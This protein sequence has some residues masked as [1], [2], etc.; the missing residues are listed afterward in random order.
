MT[1]PLGLLPG[2]VRGRDALLAELRRRLTKRS[3]VGCGTWVLAGMGGLGKSTVALAV[4]ATAREAGWR[5]WWVTA[6]DAPSLTGGMLEVLQQLG[7]PEAVTRPVREGAR[8]AAERAWE[9][10]NSAHEVGRRW[11]LIFDNADT[12]AVLAAHGS[13]CP[14]DHAGWLRPD[15]AGMILVTSRVKDPHAWGPGVALRELQPL[16]DAAAARVL[17]DL[18]PGIADPGSEQARELGRRLGGLPLAL[19]LAGSHLA[20]PF[21][22]WDTFAAYRDALD[23]TALPA[24]LAE[25]DDP[26]ARARANMQ[27]T[28]DLSLDALAADGQPQARPLLFLLACYAP[29]TPIPAALLRPEPLARLLTQESEPPAGSD[30]HARAKRDRRLR[31]GMAGLASL[32]LIDI[33]GVGSEVGA[34]AVTVHPVV[35]DVNRSRLLATAQADLP[36]IGQ[37][38][39]G[40]LQAFC[41]ELDV[42]RPSDWPT[43]RRLIPHISALL[44][45][46]ASHLDGES[47]TSLLTL[48]SSAADA[49]RH[50][51]N[52]AAAEKLATSS[53]AVS[54]PLGD[55][56]PAVLIA[57]HRLI[58]AIG[59]Q[60]RNRE[61]EQLYRGL[62]ADRQRVL[63]DE[64]P[65]T[66][67]TRHDLAWMIEYQGRYAEA[68][69]LC[70]E[71][72]T[73][74]RRM[75][76][77][78]HLS[79][80]TTGNI[81]ARVIGL[82]GRYAEAE[83]LCRQVLAKRH[84]I[85]G[86]EHPVT[87][88]TRHNLAWMIGLQG[89]YGEAEQM[90]WQLLT[91]RQRILGN[92]HPA[93]L[94][95]R[96]RLAEVIADQGL[97]RQAEQMLRQLLSQLQ[98][99]QGQGH[100]ATLTA[101][102]VLTRVIGLQGR[103]REAA[104]LHHELLTDW[105]PAHGEQEPRYLTT[106]HN[107]AWMIELQGRHAEAE[108]LLG[109]VLADREQILGD[110][111][112]DTQTTRFAL[113]EAMVGQGR[114]SEA[115]DLL[116]RVIANRERVLGDEHPDTAKAR[117]AL[118]RI[119]VMQRKPT[120]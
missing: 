71:L 5:V 17:A 110:A 81:L 77:D 59:A 49:L 9:F 99:V 15:P 22:R 4:A 25:L 83:H 11:L 48:S 38:A 105:Q 46:L 115:E 7:A 107:L 60:G 109:Q 31:D 78:A 24:A 79:T 2:E 27:Q 58:Q 68:E 64:H 39:V 53:I 112:P 92:D 1:V 35:V 88:V 50:S 65:D 37:A 8:T 41:G 6:T 101:R 55:G 80:L 23:S 16:D 91:D 96:R 120:R 89:R 61:A 86:E 76:G 30:D 42:E 29:A 3:Q 40:L 73:E 75:L 90:L 43:W 103:P 54:G 102:S 108:R 57:R 33:A 32:G 63:G 14:A 45:W 74:Q 62:L 70:R 97:Y 47:L 20:S 13:T 10:L 66:L 28:W 82:Q 106:R 119:S 114:H 44:K 52:G 12:P 117:N 113:A 21:A 72:L 56:H 67:I 111:H 51:G 85:L 36:V 26:R 69:H 95:T 100:P 34:R 93:T 19:H 87:L 18:A 104:R 116:E 98:R 118:A 84:Q 94:T